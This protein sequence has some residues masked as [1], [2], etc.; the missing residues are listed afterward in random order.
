MDLP[1]KFKLNFYFST[2]VDRKKVKFGRIPTQNFPKKSFQKQAKPR[3]SSA[4][5]IE[6]RK[7]KEFVE[8]QKPKRVYSDFIFLCKSLSS[9]KLHGWDKK[10]TENKCILEKKDPDFM[11]SKI[12]LIIDECLDF[13]IIIFGLALPDDHQV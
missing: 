12:K 13:S 4:V 7:S 9:L 2:G 8:E 6:K 1:T 5:Q 10:L 11:I 3:T